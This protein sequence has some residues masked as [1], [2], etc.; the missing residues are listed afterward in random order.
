MG[1]NVV[2]ENTGTLRHTASG[3]LAQFSIGGG[4]RK[5]VILRTCHDE[6]AA[7]RRKLAIAGLVARLRDAGYA[8]MIPNVIRDSG[9]A[10]DEEFRKIARVVTRVVT[11]KEPGLAKRHAARRDGITVAE[12]AKLWTTGDLAKQYPD[13]VKLK[14]TSDD[15]ARI[16]AWLGKVRMPDGGTFGERAVSA[17][18]LDDCDHVMG[19][20]PKTSHAASTRRNYAQAIR[21]LLVY[22]VYPLRLLPALPIPKGWLPK[23]GSDRAKAWIYPAEDLAVMQCRKVPLIRR[24]LFGLLVREGL[25]VSEALALTW[26]DLDLEHGVIRLDT[27]KTDDPRSWVLGEDVARALDAW[28]KLRGSRAKKAPRVFPAALLGHPADLA[29]LLREGL[30]LADVK[31]PE[32]IVPKAGRMLLRVH[33]LRG[34]FV[35]LALASGQTEAWVTDRTGHK[36]SAM[37]YLYKR[38]SRTAAE[39]RLGWLAPLDEAIPELDPKA[40]GGA[41]GV[42]TRGF[43]GRERSPAATRNAGKDALRTSSPRS[44]AFLKTAVLVRVPGVRIPSPPHSYA[45]FFLRPPSCRRKRTAGKTLLFSH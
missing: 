9:A 7:L 27:N 25:R 3:Y 17:V 42:Q 39:L 36:S 8:A 10:G 38:A 24:L 11:G 16:F 21:R 32:L 31:R 26:S 33:D 44:N 30:A 37:I 19:A 43:R 14:K 22:A 40:P 12:L 34:S 28:R 35:T 2:A 20:L 15:D 45:G 6:D 5:G 23:G 1:T 18:N 41:N 4:K 13:H 29:R